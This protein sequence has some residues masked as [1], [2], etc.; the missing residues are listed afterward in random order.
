MLKKLY[1]FFSSY[2]IIV[3][4]IAARL[5]LLLL[6][7]ENENQRRAVHHDGVLKCSCL[8]GD[9]FDQKGPQSSY[10]PILD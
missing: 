9:L 7:P 1:S 3:I 2:A 8:E 6:L 5:L 10:Y 4:F